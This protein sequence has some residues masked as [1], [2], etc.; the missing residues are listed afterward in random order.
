MRRPATFLVAAL[1]AAATACASP[2]GAPADRPGPA[3]ADAPASAPA[4]PA[5]TP[6]AADAAPADASA[7]LFTEDQATRGRT[8]FRATCADCHY[9]SEF[10]DAQFKFNWGKRTV[11]DLYRNIVENMPEDAPGSLP[12]QQYVDVVTYIL[13]LNGFPPGP[14]EL[15]GDEEAMGAVILEAPTGRSEP[16]AR[17]PSDAPR[18]PF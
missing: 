1:T 13:Q 16:F 5:R 3:A 2:G 18:S 8:T 12:P 14:R 11:A 9:S 15:T 4:G 6:A 10:R 17:R 7:G